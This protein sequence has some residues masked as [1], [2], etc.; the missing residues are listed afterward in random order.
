MDRISRKI[1]ERSIICLFLFFQK[2]FQSKKKFILRSFV[3]IHRQMCFWS[4]FLTKY[5]IFG[6]VLET[7]NLYCVKMSCAPTNFCLIYAKAPS[8][9]KELVP[10][11]KSK[12]SGKERKERRPKKLRKKCN[13]VLLEDVQFAMFS[14]LIIVPWN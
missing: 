11:P 1:W 7:K 8:K 12:K 6:Q 9:V 2:K 10:L 5:F 14:A 13:V 4:F 3:L